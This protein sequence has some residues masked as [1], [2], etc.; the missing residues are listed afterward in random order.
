M[1]LNLSTKIALLTAVL[2]SVF[3]A[4]IL[5]AFGLL[6]ARQIDRTIE[7]DANLAGHQ[8]SVYLGERSAELATGSGCDE[9]PHPSLLMG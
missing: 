4:V 3:G 5:A 7:A 6:S 8:L 2:L 1:R 9:L